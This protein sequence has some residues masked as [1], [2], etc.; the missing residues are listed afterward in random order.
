QL[1]PYMI[2]YLHPHKERIIAKLE[3]IDSWEEA[4]VVVNKSIYLP[5]T[6]LPKLKKG[7][8]YFHDIIGYTVEDEKLGRLG[9]ITCYFTETPQP[10]LGMSYQ[11]KE[12]LIPV[13]DAI[14]GMPNEKMKVI[15]VRLP[16]GLIEVYLDDTH[17]KDDD[18]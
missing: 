1:V 18:E 4:Q 15:P 9:T 5:L 13:N 3:G 16:E 8:Y 14:V 6:A 10:L 11:G 12:V 17:V 2:E 7:Q